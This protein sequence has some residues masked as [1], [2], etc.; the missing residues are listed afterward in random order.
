[1]ATTT[2]LPRDT[3]ESAKEA[4]ALLEPFF[5]AWHDSDPEGMVSRI[6][7]GK[8]DYI[9]Y[10]SSPNKLES[11]DAIRPFLTGFFQMASDF[12]YT[13]VS[14]YGDRCQL[15]LEA[16]IS[17][18]LQAELPGFPLKKG[19]TATLPGVSII[20]MDED[21]MVVFKHDY[22]LLSHNS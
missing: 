14:A 16:I 19:D 8:V 9:D 18:K 5:K 7:D 21:G 10:L 6:S 3:P 2:N 12:T 13:T 22:F 15:T 17:F 11:K 20:K 4:M 1:M